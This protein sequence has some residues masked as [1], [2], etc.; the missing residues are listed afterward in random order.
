MPKKSV[1][2]RDLAEHRLQVQIDAAKDFKGRRIFIPGNHDW[3]NGTD[4]LKRQERF[5]EDALGKD[6]FLPE[7]GC[8]IEKVAISDDIVLILV[9]S[10]WYI[11]NW[12][13]HPNINDNCEI[14]TRNKFL[15][16]FES[17]IKK[18]RGKT[19]IVAIHHPM[20]T[21]GPHGGQYSAKQWLKPLPLLGGIV[22]KTGGVSPSDMQYPLY[23][24][25]RK[26]MITLAQE[27]DKVVFCV[28]P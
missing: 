28:R 19:T 7:N 15:D 3:Y 17:Q 27:N 20:F 13:K 26:H 2:G 12:D 5:V 11:T 23:N 1:D 6:S 21:N 8:P 24:E 9:D 16:E 14:K 4:G 22:R 18:A 10:E 25:L